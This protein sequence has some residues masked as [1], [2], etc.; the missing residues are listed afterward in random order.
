MGKKKHHKAV[1][2][3]H[4][5][6]C[7]LAKLAPIYL[8]QEWNPLI[9]PETLMEL[10]LHM[11]DANPQECAGLFY[12]NEETNTIEWF[13]RD[14]QA[15]EFGG[16]VENSMD[17][18]MALAVAQIGK[19]PNGHWHTH[20]LF[21][22]FWS[23]TDTNQQGQMM[24]GYDEFYFLVWS[25][26]ALRARHIKRVGG[27]V[28][29]RDGFAITTYNDKPLRLAEA[30]RWT[31]GKARSVKTTKATEVP[32]GV[33]GELSP[34]GERALYMGQWS[35]NDKAY[36]VLFDHYAV[37]KYEWGKLRARVMSRFPDS[38][39][40]DWYSIIDNPQHWGDWLG[41]ECPREILN[42]YV[43]PITAG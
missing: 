4:Q 6:T 34:E 29:I 25:G 20:P 41:I 14:I 35:S 40:N 37:P 2:R 43:E 21:S 27:A 32:Y 30:A 10:H 39:D 33:S 15:L 19:L 9:A 36:D 8:K 26:A 38:D 11:I 12:Y 7:S 16:F 31:V 17:Y 3:V 23:G 42:E 24:A 22:S 5:H 1:I 18:P 13:G 28:L